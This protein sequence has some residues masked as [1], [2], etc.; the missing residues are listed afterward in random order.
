MEIDNTKALAA[1]KRLIG[2]RIMLASHAADLR[3][4]GF[5]M[6]GVD[7]D[8]SPDEWW[9]HILCSWRLESEETIVTGSFDWNQPLA[10]HSEWSADWDPAHGGS[11]EEDRLRVLFKD[12]GSGRTIKNNTELFVVQDVD[13]SKYGDLELKLTGGLRLR[14]FPAGSRGEFWRV[15][16]KDDLGSHFVCERD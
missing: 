10:A 14:V 5:R 16:R 3:G 1:V 6:P 13:V 9:L 12:F 4:F 2:L 7:S 8:N 11:L 15:F